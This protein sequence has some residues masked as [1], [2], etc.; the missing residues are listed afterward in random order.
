M[1]EPK[2]GVDVTSTDNEVV[3]IGAGYAGLAAALALH[4]AGR[5]VVV[6][7]ARR[8]VGGRVETEHHDGVP[9][10]L[11]GMWVGADHTRFRALLAR[12]GITVFPT[13]EH[14]RTGWWDREARILRPA[15]VL[16]APWSA[17]PAAAAAVARIERLARRVPVGEP[18]RAEDADTWDAVTVADW[19][20]RRVPSAEARALLD[21]ILVAS[22]SVELS[23]V[24]MLNLFATAADAGGLLR[25]LGTEGGAQQDLVTGG[26]DAPARAVAELLGDRVR[27]AC[28]VREVH[29][30]GTSVRV[31]TDDGVLRARRAI[32]ALPPGLAAALGWEPALPGARR[33]LLDRLSMGSVTKLLAV[34]DRP[35][36]RDGGWSGEVV[37]T[38]G[39]VSTAFDATQPGGAPVLA[40]LTCGHRSLTLSRLS[41]DERR[42]RILAAFTD[43]FGHEAAAPR[44]VVERSWENE[45]WS[46]GGYSA[47]PVPGSLASMPLVAEP[48]G[49]VHVAGTETAVRSSGF[50]DGAIAS[51]ERAAREVVAALR[52]GS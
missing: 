6:L 46:G 33:Q 19:L 24:S 11:G 52:A 7:E 15:R 26:A 40:S 39:P 36:W 18:W 12:F 50:V 29:H 35:F 38:H 47:I 44:I 5:D 1:T 20:R 28:P 22:F 3:V 34:Y 16:P 13:P 30:D 21:S 27:L 4:D 25:L 41:S 37:D 17:L 31:A 49:C 9:L 32:V 45:E 10:D 48:I 23:Q 8:R 51:G 43:W 42:D 14:G 2:E